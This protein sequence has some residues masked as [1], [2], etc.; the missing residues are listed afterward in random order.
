MSDNEWDENDANTVVMDG[1]DLG[2]A[3]DSDDAEERSSFSFHSVTMMSPTTHG[4]GM[5]RYTTYAVSAI[6]SATSNFSTVH[7]RYSDF[8]WLYGRLQ[9]ERP[10]A[11]VPL[12][13]HT[14]AISVGSRVAAELVST[15]RGHLVRFMER[16][17]RHPECADAPALTV[18]LLGTDEI[19]ASARKRS[20]V[21]TTADAAAASDA[22]EKSVQAKASASV[23]HL[24]AK[25]KVKIS[26]AT[27]A[28]KL[29]D[30]S[31][32]EDFEAI[33]KYQHDLAARVRKLTQDAQTL[34]R[35]SR[36]RARAL[37]ELADTLSALGRGE[38]ADL[39]RGGANCER[40]DLGGDVGG[41]P[42]AAFIPAAMDVSASLV[43]LHGAS[44]ALAIVEEAEFH[45]PLKELA[46]DTA[47]L[48]VALERRRERQVAFTA[49]RAT[50]QAKR[51]ALARTRADPKPKMEERVARV[52]AE[53]TLS[54]KRAEGAGKDLDAASRRM[55]REVPR[56]RAEVREKILAVVAAY[57]R[58]QIGYGG[59]AA[60]QWVAMLQVLE[61]ARP[62]AP[63]QAPP[64]VPP[65]PEAEVDTT[66]TELES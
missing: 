45:E 38:G 32:D 37:R 62:A 47:A 13:P 31:D 54:D 34:V 19:F 5:N 48:A 26:T 25:V 33:V 55:L 35:G 39:G 24:M 63:L 29:D 53:L 27:G 49:R 56:F 30:I 21:E 8:Q 59:N 16:I 9:A 57:T 18:F 22:P 7:R 6:D 1:D 52:Q 44:D 14:R 65:E 10:G 42:D 58:L 61:G 41:D 15:R 12:I 23:L 64:E 66:A 4:E 36:E 28:A 43:S 46:D 20:A 3:G 11:I 50:Q 17:I 40:A 51:N 2:I 60:P